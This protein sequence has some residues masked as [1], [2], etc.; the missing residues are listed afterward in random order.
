MSGKLTT[1]ILIELSKEHHIKPFNI[2]IS[3]YTGVLVITSGDSWQP[4]KN[5]SV[6]SESM[7]Q[8]KEQ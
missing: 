5:R 7:A 3:S 6:I 1:Q 8:R 4:P 2:Y